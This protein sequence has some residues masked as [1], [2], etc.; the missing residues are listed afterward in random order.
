VAVFTGGA[1]GAAP[2]QA[3]LAA[4]GLERIEGL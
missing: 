2:Y 1:A 3:G 4:Y